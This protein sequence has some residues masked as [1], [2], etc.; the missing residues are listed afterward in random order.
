MEIK[1]YHIQDLADVLHITTRTALEYCENGTIKARKIGKRWTV[2][3]DNL[4]EF[5]NTP[6][7]RPAAAE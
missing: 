1:I 5:I 7:N 6:T 3:H 4:L 2:S